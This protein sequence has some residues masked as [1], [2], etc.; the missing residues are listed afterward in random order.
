MADKVKIFISWGGPRAKAYAKVLRKWLVG[1][2]NAEPFVSSEDVQAGEKNISKIIDQLQS[3]KA[4]IVVATPGSLDSKWVNFEAGYMAFMVAGGDERRVIPLLL[5]GVKKSDLEGPLTSF[6]AVEPHDEDLKH[7]TRS[8]CQV[9]GID[10]DRIDAKVEAMWPTLNE[11]LNTV[12]L[13]PEVAPQPARDIADV[14]EEV[15]SIVRGLRNDASSSQ[16]RPSERTS[17]SFEIK[18][19]PAA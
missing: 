8:L 2:D 18:D 1:F 17:V 4:G 3:S 15:L 13:P 10:A 16:F 7:L 9:L 12:D 11:A 14:M 5:D 6:Q 19:P